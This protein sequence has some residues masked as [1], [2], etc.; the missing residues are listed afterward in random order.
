MEKKNGYQKGTNMESAKQGK[1]RLSAEK[2]ETMFS[3]LAPEARSVFLSGDFNHWDSSS[4]PLV[5]GKNGVW[6]TSLFLDPGPHQYN[7]FVDGKWQNDPDC[8]SYIP[9]AVGTSNC[10]KIVG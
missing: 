6:R 4:H 3:L 1:E 9:S 7:F 5:K 2:I 8:H 10:L